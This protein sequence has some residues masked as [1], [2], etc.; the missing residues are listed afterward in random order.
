M[1]L[2]TVAFFFHNSILGEV[3]SWKIGILDQI[4]SKI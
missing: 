1:I 2:F 3:I 4:E